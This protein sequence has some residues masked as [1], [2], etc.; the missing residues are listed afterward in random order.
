MHPGIKEAN[1]ILNFFQRNELKPD[2]D[3]CFR[4]FQKW[5]EEIEVLARSSKDYHKM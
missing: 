4:D 5:Q 3:E 1:K 2:A